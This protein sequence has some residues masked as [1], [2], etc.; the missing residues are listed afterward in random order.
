M[1]LTN[2]VINKNSVTMYQHLDNENIEPLISIETRVDRAFWN[3]RKQRVVRITKLL[4]E[5][6]GDWTNRI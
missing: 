5:S 6:N 1:N 4:G 3:A 2:K